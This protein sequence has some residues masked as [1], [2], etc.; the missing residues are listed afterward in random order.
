MP[1]LFY[2]S[3]HFS[4][5]F[6]IFFIISLGS[7]FLRIRSPFFLIF[8][9][10]YIRFLFLLRL[11][12]FIK[13]FIVIFGY[14]VFFCLIAFCLCN[15]QKLHFHVKYFRHSIFI[16]LLFIELSKNSS[17]RSVNWKVK[18]LIVLQRHLCSQECFFLVINFISYTVTIRIFST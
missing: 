13:F 1:I 5:L 17:S 10:H 14:F 16:F 4:M 15:I 3:F 6:C 9:S 7:L 12:Q 11:H 2:F 8:W 18:L